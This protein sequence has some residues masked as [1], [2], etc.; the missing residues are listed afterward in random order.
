MKVN[1]L[2]CVILVPG[3][4]THIQKNSNIKINCQDEQCAKQSSGETGN[5]WLLQ[6]AMKVCITASS[7]HGIDQVNRTFDVEIVSEQ[8]RACSLSV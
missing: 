2:L 5:S 6:M 4:H 8:D 7:L 1:S 3:I